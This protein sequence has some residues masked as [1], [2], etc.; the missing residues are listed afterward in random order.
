MPGLFMAIP[1][2]GYCQESA[3]LSAGGKQIMALF[4]SGIRLV[5]VNACIVA[6]INLAA[7]CRLRTL[8]HQSLL[9]HTKR[10]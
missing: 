8:F 5:K 1:L 3:R 6:R 7:L 4:L 2:G 9:K 10:R